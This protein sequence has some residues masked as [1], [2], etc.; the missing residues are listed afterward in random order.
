[1]ARCPHC[2]AALETPLACGAC[3]RL[4]DPGAEISPFAALGLEPRFALEPGE[5]RRRLLRATRLTH[6]DF[7]GTA[8]AGARAL[9]E[10]NTAR[11]NA[12]YE[13]LA[14]DVAR[15]DWLVGA[16]G[17]PDEIAERSMPQP[18]L[19]EVLDW[20]EMLEGARAGGRAAAQDPRLG[21]LGTEL[22]AR[23]AAAVRSIGAR[24]DPL[25]QP[26]SAPLREVRRELNAIRYLDR[27]LAELEALRLARAEAR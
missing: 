23:R 24:L 18:F 5:L 1:M 26:G 9:A 7:F 11:L 2:G 21:E 16:L 27:A 6:P 14:D 12:A 19:L 25:P 8:D 22:A 20:N 3:G 15:A 13:V 17:G 10:R 4:I